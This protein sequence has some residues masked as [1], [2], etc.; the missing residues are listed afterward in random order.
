MDFPSAAIPFDVGQR[1][2]TLFELARWLK[3]REPNAS[4][5]RQLEIVCLWH[6]KHL[7]IIRTKDFE[8]S[9]TDF[10]Y[11]LARIKQPY[12]ATLQ[13]CL[14][15]LPPAPDIPELFQYGA[16]AV[17]LIRICMA[18][19]LHHGS[20]PIYLGCRKAGELI[21]Y[22][23]TDTAKLLQIFVSEGWLIEVKRGVGSRASRY[24][25]VV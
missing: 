12:G 25:V 16:K 21:D 18:L 5:N 2:R 15:E 1:H 14:S 6:A 8:T 23:H 19:Q 20:E 7:H 9:W 24:K 4:R 22:N 3:G 10:R 13:S 17:H 11:A